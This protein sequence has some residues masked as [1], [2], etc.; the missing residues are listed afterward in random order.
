MSRIPN[1]FASRW[2]YISIAA[3][4][5][6]LTTSAGALYIGSSAMGL[7]GDMRKTWQ[8]FDQV[9]EIK[10]TY[11]TQMHRYLGYSGM[12]QHLND[13]LLHGKEHL[14]DILDIDLDQAKNA[15]DS[16]GLLDVNE[17]EKAALHILRTLI[18]K[19]RVQIQDIPKLRERGLSPSEIDKKIDLFPQAATAALDQLR[20]SWRQQA[21]ITKQTMD[22]NAM[23][24]EK[25]VH[26]SWAFIPVMVLFGIT[27][28]WLVNKLCRQVSAYE[29][30]KVALE[31][32]ERKFRDMAANVPGV[33]FQWYE[34]SGGERGYLY[35]SPRCQELYGVSPAELQRNWNALSIH[36]D[37]KKRYMKTVDEAFKKRAEWSFEG[38]FLTPGGEEKWWRGISKPMP[39]NDEITVHNGV[40]ID[41]SLQKKM[42]EELRSLATLDGLTGAYN[43][44]HFL[45]KAATEVPR[46][47]R[48]EHPLTVLMIDLD[49]FK[50][51]NDTY[52]H[53][54]GDEVLR[55][56]V[57]I[58]RK[59]LR[60]PDV[61][62]RI[63]GEEFAL[64]LPETNIAGA[65]TLA[66][67]MRTDLQNTAIPWDKRTIK[68]TASIG[69]AMLNK[70]DKDIHDILARAD[71]A[72]YNAKAA[73]RNCV[74]YCEEPIE[75]QAQATTERLEFAS[76]TPRPLDVN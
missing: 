75:L 19:S 27:I 42:E 64:M 55:R 26:M 25:L 76:P 18:Q 33:I 63:G 23:A 66:E 53:G 71:R 34:R 39:G 47:Q 8:N 32:S 3:A 62:G 31:K 35:V 65:I 70:A 44:R 51:V 37:D 9:S 72:L 68:V 21:Q 58:V 46:S 57:E 15:V 73:G 30:E 1:P 12:A 41:I 45:Y 11:L 16:Y 7:F 43:R 59:S 28:F 74:M 52:G 2:S 24:A 29:N 49:L 61:L 56:F 13:Y 17:D 4:V 20:M 69:I 38:R 48:Y 10:I 6:I 5:L 36:P 14:L 67:R 60:G 40:I 22:D 50:Q 54:G